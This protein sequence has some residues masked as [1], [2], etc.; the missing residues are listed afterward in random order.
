VEGGAAAHP[1]VADGGV[2][3]RLRRAARRGPPRARRGLPRRHRDPGAPEGGGRQGGAAANALG[4]SRGGYGTKACAACDARGRPLGFALLPGQAAEL[5]AAP[6]LLA[7]AAL[8]GA[9]LRVVCDASYSAAAWRA[10]VRAFG[11]EP[12]VRPNPTHP[13]APPHDRAAYRRRHRVENLW[14]RLKEW[15]AVATRYDK[16]AAS[17]LGGLHLAAACDWLSNRP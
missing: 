16:T 9:I 1:L 6:A 12:V 8:L 17:F 5:K 10:L 4:R 13:R 2:G 14:A 3:A 7:L 15:R 11:A